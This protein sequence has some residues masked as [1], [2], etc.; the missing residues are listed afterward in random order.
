MDST[1]ID[2]FNAGETGC[3]RLCHRQ[4]S[5]IARAFPPTERMANESVLKENRK[6]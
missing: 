3:E 1:I 6:N 2:V 5:P 4:A